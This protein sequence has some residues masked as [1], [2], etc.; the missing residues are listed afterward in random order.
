[1]KDKNIE[2]NKGRRK[3]EGK[4][5]NLRVCIQKFPDWPP[6]ARTANGTAL[7]HNIRFYRYFVSHSSEFCRHDSLCCF[8]WSVY[9]CCLFR[10]DSVRKLLDI[11]SKYHDGGGG[12]SLQNCRA[13]ILK[14]LR[15]CRTTILMIAC[16]DTFKYRRRIITQRACVWNDTSH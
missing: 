8:S 14:Q 15:N 5:D 11:P 9:Y 3:T 13:V 6:G 16:D 4:K 7:C 1:M 12:H 10:H 2:I